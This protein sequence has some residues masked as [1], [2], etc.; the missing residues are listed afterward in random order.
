MLTAG[1]T[2]VEDVPLDGAA[3][4]TYVRS[5]HAHARITGIDVSE[6]EQSPGVVAIFTGED[7]A[8]LGLAPHANPALPEGM[9][10]PFVA[11]GT[12]RYV[13]QP[14]V[15]IVAEDRAQ[16]ADAADLVVIDFEPLPAR[17]RPGGCGGRRGAAVP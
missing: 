9:R 3:W 11:A 12:V 6:A 14:V 10:R 16:G 1:G 13:G 8:E 5:P 2:Y 4:V 17:R 15:A 7:L